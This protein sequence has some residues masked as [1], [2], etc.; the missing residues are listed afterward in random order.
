MW[1]NKLNYNWRERKATLQKTLRK[2]NQLRK[3]LL[4]CFVALFLSLYLVVRVYRYV[5]TPPN[6]QQILDIVTTYSRWNIFPSEI[7]AVCHP[8][9]VGVRSATES[10]GFVT[11]LSKA[12][13]SKEFIDSFLGYIKEKRTTVVVVGG[14]PPGAKRFLKAL[15]SE[16][17]IIL[18]VAIYH[19]SPTLHTLNAPESS[20]MSEIIESGITGLSDRTG[21][22]KSSL[23]PSFKAL[24]G[25]VF[26]VSNFILEHNVYSSI[27]YSVFDGRIHV[28]VFGSENFWKNVPSQV[29]AACRLD[30]RII[31]HTLET[32]TR[33]LYYQ[34]CY[35]P[36]R[37]HPRTTRAPFT[38][39]LSKMDVGMYVSLTECQPMMALEYLQAG[40]P[41]VISDTSSIF[42]SS[43]ELG[44]LL[45]C[46]SQDKVDEISFC[47]NRVLE[48]PKDKMKLLINVFLKDFH[49]KGVAQLS[50][51][52]DKPLLENPAKCKLRQVAEINPSPKVIQRE[53]SSVAIV[54]YELEG[55][56]PGGAGTLIASLVKL[57]LSKDIEVL[58]LYDSMPKSNIQVWQRKFNSNIL[59]AFRLEDLAS[60]MSKTTFNGNI[61]AQK[62]MQWALGLE[63]LY[64]I[65]SF[66]AVEL[67]DYAGPST[68][69]LLRQLCNE[70]IIPLSVT[71]IVR[72][73][74][75]LEIIDTAESALVTQM[76]FE[77]NLMER[78]SLAF[79]DMV[80]FPSKFLLDFYS[81]ALEM[82]FGHGVVAV[83]PINT[84]APFH[85]TGLVNT[86]WQQ[87]NILVLG[88]IQA[89]KGVFMIVEA[90]K[91][92]IS[93]P[94]V[95]LKPFTLDF[96]GI[97]WIDTVTKQSTVQE[98]AAVIPPWL[99]SYV[100]IMG[101]VPHADLPTFIRKYR[102][103]VFASAFESFCYA[104]HELHAARIPLIIS[105][106]HAFKAFSSAVSFK[107]KSNNL[108][109]LASAIHEAIEDDDKI[110]AKSTSQRLSYVSPFV[111]YKNV[112]N[113]EI[114]HVDNLLER[115]K[116]SDQITNAF[117]FVHT[118]CS[119]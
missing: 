106:A 74:G 48:Y 16:F 63:A 40:V 116:L 5:S 110:K 98:L 60:S 109:S 108:E 57:L 115:C 62:S 47:L 84:L 90:L 24:G 61:F 13:D 3:L 107:W 81:T 19:G 112:F 17:P 37:Y 10:L 1:T 117:P 52:L 86:P 26:P 104:A 103:A 89:N 82:D 67:F 46:S 49:N 36:V 7:V 71:V 12:L 99:Q 95:Q 23:I 28:G 58:L 33:Q 79:A 77:R 22:L 31:V 105:D 78:F 30:K 119:R 29:W 25:S 64:K 118:Q 42:P 51:I 11:V 54:T 44:S 15:R 73:H 2:R 111:A 94:E 21:L 50:A 41:V 91:L 14:W 43:S 113:R 72:T 6:A 88:K 4:G 59:H 56:A 39:L 80:F 100:R 70:S 93:N 87:K 85:E 97:D 38:A 75:S 66:D 35:N 8:D 96:V 53:R 102:A 34:Y 32:S 55:V 65:K 9:W 101:P 76:N 18:R 20:A 83:P 92:L 69:F 27:K 68:A 114:P 45:I